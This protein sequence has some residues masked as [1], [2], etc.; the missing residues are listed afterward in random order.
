MVEIT[1]DEIRFLVFE[2]VSVGN[3]VGVTAILRNILP[4]FLGY[5]GRQ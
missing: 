2:D 3:V 1:A 4:P 5:E